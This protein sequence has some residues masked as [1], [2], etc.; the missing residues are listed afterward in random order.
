MGAI[1]EDTSAI[2][3][4]QLTKEKAEKHASLQKDVKDLEDKVKREEEEAK[5]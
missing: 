3:E 1:T 5:K 2:T 4:A